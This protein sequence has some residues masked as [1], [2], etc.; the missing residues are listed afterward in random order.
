MG[1]NLA[2]FHLVQVT[3]TPKFSPFPR[4]AP[5]KKGQHAASQYLKAGS[6]EAVLRGCKRLGCAD[7]SSLGLGPTG[8]TGR[9]LEDGSPKGAEGWVRYHLAL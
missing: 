2:H 7:G 4:T 5:Q 8:H 9:V 3:C 6:T 1:Y